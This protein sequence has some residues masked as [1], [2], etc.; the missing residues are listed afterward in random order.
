MSDLLRAINVLNRNSGNPEVAVQAA[1]KR[2]VKITDTVFHQSGTNFFIQPTGNRG[3]DHAKLPGGNYAVKFNPVQGFYLEIISDFP[4]M[5]KIY[6][7]TVENAKRILNTYSAKNGNLGVLLDGLKGSGKTLLARLISIMGKERGIPTL[8]INSA[9]TGES[10]FHF[11][12]SIQQECIVFFD[13]FEKV[14][15]DKEQESLLTVLDGTFPS[16]KLFLLTSNDKSKVNNHLKNRPGRI[17]YYLHFKGLSGDFIREFVSD[18]LKN[19]DH[20]KELLSVCGMFQAMNFDSLATMVWEMNLYNEPAGKAVQMLNTKPEEGG[21]D[22]FDLE[23]KVDGCNFAFN[24]D[25]LMSDYIRGNPL[26]I[27]A[28]EVRVMI[29]AIP[30]MAAK[31]LGVPEKVARGLH[32]SAFDDTDRL[33]EENKENNITNKTSKKVDWSDHGYVE[34]Y[35]Y[36]GT[37]RVPLVR[38]YVEEATEVFHAPAFHFDQADLVSIGIETGEYIFKNKHGGTLTATRRVKEEKTVLDYLQYM[39]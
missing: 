36:E 5:G 37:V 39:A 7:N 6:G 27:G 21:I 26:T 34:R 1:E 12:Y 9:L 3:I 20:E 14:Y 38:A 35:R 4:A 28:Q 15:D 22:Y 30:E 16:K 8:I 23:F 18:N 29:P 19:K 33:I 25:F 13:E 31:M 10:F 17:H 32:Q 11:L 2:V 24:K